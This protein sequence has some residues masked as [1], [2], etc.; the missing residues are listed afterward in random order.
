MSKKSKCLFFWIFSNSRSSLRDSFRSWIT[1]SGE[2]IVKGSAGAGDAE[3]QNCPANAKVTQGGDHPSVHDAFDGCFCIPGTLASSAANAV[4]ITILFCKLLCPPQTPQP[5]LPTPP[6]LKPCLT[7]K[8]AWCCLQCPF[9]VSP[10]SGHLT[11]AF[12]EGNSSVSPV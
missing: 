5:I 6:A 7:W 1:L 12:P 11:G 9:L 8:G 10:V 2:E 3:L 4:H